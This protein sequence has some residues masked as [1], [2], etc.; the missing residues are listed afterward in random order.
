MPVHQMAPSGASMGKQEA[1]CKPL[2]APITTGKLLR[3]VAGF[4]DKNLEE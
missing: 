4:G 2:A 1:T 3:L